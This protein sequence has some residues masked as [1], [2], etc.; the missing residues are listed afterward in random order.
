LGTEH[1]AWAKLDRQHRAAAPFGKEVPRLVGVWVSDVAEAP[2]KWLKGLVPDVLILND[3]NIR[4]FQKDVHGSTMTSRDIDRAKFQ[5]KSGTVDIYVAGFPCNP[6]S[7]RGCHRS[8]GAC[9]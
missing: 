5:V 8:R 6:W 4:T 3:I 1:I 9:E 2:R 7:S